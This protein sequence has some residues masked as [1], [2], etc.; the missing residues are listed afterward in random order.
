M[1]FFIQY[2]IR[3][4]QAHQ[5]KKEKQNLILKIWFTW[6]ESNLLSWTLLSLPNYVDIE[7]NSVESLTN[8]SKHFGISFLTSS[9]KY[10][11]IGK[12]KDELKD[13]KTMLNEIRKLE[14][15]KQQKINEI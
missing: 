6:K 12:F 5:Q 9:K 1:L 2:R 10:T 4:C 8:K 3:K 15:L 13:L 11:M 7:Y 14:L